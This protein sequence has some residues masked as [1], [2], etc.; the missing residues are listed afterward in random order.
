M[1]KV[2]SSTKAFI[3]FSSHDVQK[4]APIINKANGIRFE[5]FDL[6]SWSKSTVGHFDDEK[7]SLYLV[8]SYCGVRSTRYNGVQVAVTMLA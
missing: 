5:T 3:A 7:Q 4:R 1:V 6:V 8:S 2:F